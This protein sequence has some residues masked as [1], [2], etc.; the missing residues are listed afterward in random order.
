[1]P[2]F[3][4]LT[5]ASGRW[6][7]RQQRRAKMGN[8]FPSTPPPVAGYIGWYTVESFSGSTWTDLSGNGNNATVTR[9]SVSTVA[10]TGNGASATFNTLQGTT[11]DGIQFPVSILPSTYTLFHLTRHTG[12]A[13]RIFTGITNNWLSGHWSG[14]TGVA[15]HEGWLTGQPNLHGSNWF[16]STDQVNLY[17]SNMVTRGSSG[18]TASTRLSINAGVN[19]EYSSWQV[20]EV[21]VYNTALSSDNYISVENYFNTK[22]G[23]GL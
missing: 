1:M 18:G 6:S 23:L 5:S 20:A 17:R 2:D 7:L 9:G 16:I 21:I 14:A 19:A 3:P 11:S 8:N 10:G 12:T 22:Y 15:Y 13:S 4:S